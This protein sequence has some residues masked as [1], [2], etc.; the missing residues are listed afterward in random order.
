MTSA[1]IQ[2]IF[3]AFLIIAA[4]AAIPTTVPVLAVF[5]TTENVSFSNV[6]PNTAVLHGPH[7]GYLAM[8]PYLVSTSPSGRLVCVGW[9]DSSNINHN[10]CLT[11]SGS[12]S[13]SGTSIAA[14]DMWINVDTVTMTING[15]TTFYWD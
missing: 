9:A 2:R 6:S 1:K 11:V 5:R 7:S 14:Y 4:L 13:G 8:Y 3:V 15:Q 12:G 10:G